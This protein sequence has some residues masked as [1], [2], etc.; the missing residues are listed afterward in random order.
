MLQTL[1]DL[2]A[3]RHRSEPF[4]V[5]TIRVPY[6]VSPEGGSAVR[7]RLNEVEPDFWQFWNPGTFHAYF[8]ASRSGASRART[9][10]DSLEP[11]RARD[12]SL[13]DFESTLTEGTLLGS[14]DRRGRVTSMP[15]GTT[16][17]P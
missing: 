11:L 16:R 14:F 3:P 17:R 1:R 2:L 10:L 4:V 8:R 7:D 5:V 13:A 6:G 9:C 15:L 12:R